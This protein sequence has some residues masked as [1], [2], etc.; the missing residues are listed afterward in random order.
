MNTTRNQVV[1][2][3]ADIATAQWVLST[4]QS[5]C[6]H[7]FLLV[8]QEHC[9]FEGSGMKAELRCEI[10]DF[11]EVK[12]TEAP[13]CPKHLV[14]MKSRWGEEAKRIAEP[15]EQRLRANPERLYYAPFVYYC[16]R[17]GCEEHVMLE[18][19]DQ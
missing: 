17:E 3:K 9:D 11:D 14:E 7:T 8:T 1:V 10:C 18:Q 16:P 5:K 13:L 12:D 4:L 19:W 2:A 15:T 6:Q